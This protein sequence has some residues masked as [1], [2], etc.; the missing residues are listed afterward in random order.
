MA[1][2]GPP[3]PPP[4]SSSVSAPQPPHPPPHS[5]ITWDGDKMSA[6]LLFP[7]H[8]PISHPSPSLSH[9]PS[10]PL[11]RFN[12]YILDYC[13]KRG[14]HKTANQLVTEADIPPESKPPINAQQG[15]LFECVSSSLPILV[16]TALPLP[17]ADGGVSSGC[18]FKPKTAAMVLRMQCCI[19]RSVTSI[20]ISHVVLKIGPP[21]SDPEITR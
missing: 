6:S 15:L 2:T 5:E 13:K 20:P 14:Y 9:T 3:Q 18:Y 1:T 10:F 4:G 8:S 11:F 16:S 21:A 19:I 12:I 7:L 17:P